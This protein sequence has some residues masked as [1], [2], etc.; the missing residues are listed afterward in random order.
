MEMVLIQ[1]AN[2]R[3]RRERNEIAHSSYITYVFGTIWRTLSVSEGRRRA[4]YA[5][6]SMAARMVPVFDPIQ[7]LDVLM[8]YFHIEC[9]DS[10]QLVMAKVTLPSLHIVEQ[11]LVVDSDRGL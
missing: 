7:W 5:L 8:G 9:P 3:E 11:I 6:G 1:L 2:T 4:T 10:T